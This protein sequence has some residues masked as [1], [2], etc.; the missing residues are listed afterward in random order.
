MPGSTRTLKIETDSKL[1]NDV[2]EQVDFTLPIAKPL[3][4]HLEQ[5]CEQDSMSL[6]S[7]LDKLAGNEDTHYAFVPS[8]ETISWHMKREELNVEMIHGHQRKRPQGAI[9]DSGRTWLIWHFDEVEKKLK[10]QRIVILDKH[11]HDRNLREIAGLI[12]FAQFVG[13]TSGFSTMLIW[14]PGEVTRAVAELLASKYDV[15]IS[16]EDREGSIPCARR[17]YDQAQD[18]CMWEVNE[19]Y[20]W[21]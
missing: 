20:A 19:Y 9:S 18:G 12:Q 16:I 15:K 5:L 6:Q 21:C 1:W 4:E 17:R 11:E 2:H 13:K 8:Y 14:N 10:I 7:E 3:M